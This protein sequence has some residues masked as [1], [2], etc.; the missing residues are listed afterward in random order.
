MTAR[1]TILQALF[2]LLQTVPSVKVIRNE[3]FPEKIPEGGL[4]VMRDGDPGEPEV[5]LSPTT[6]YW[7]H[8]VLLEVAVQ[9]GVATARDTA[10]DTLFSQIAGVIASNN[11]LNGLCDLVIPLAPDTNTLAIEGAATVK[12]AIV[13]LTLIYSTADQLG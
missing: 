7:Q 9:K 8:R 2:A 6:Y 10:L 11:T 3:V 5:F 13:S 1:E 4:I 12:T